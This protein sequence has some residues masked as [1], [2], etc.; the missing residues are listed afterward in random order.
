MT[1]TFTLAIET[2]V[3]DGSLALF[4]NDNLIDGWTGEKNISR[5]DRLLPIISEFLNRNKI[6]KKDLNLIAVSR[7]P[8]NFTGARI[9]LAT[10][11]GLK[12]GLRVRCVGVSL[13]HALAA[14]SSPPP[15]KVITAIL[16][17]K[18]EV[19]R[20]EHAAES[21]TSV[22]TPMPS[23]AVN[24]QATINKTENKTENKAEDATQNKTENKTEVKSFDDFIDEIASVGGETEVIVERRLYEMIGKTLE[25]K[26]AQFGFSLETPL[27]LRNVGDNLSIAV[28]NYAL[29]DNASDN[30]KAIYLGNSNANLKFS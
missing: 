25:L 23:V 16:T 26:T 28:G 30:I 22:K 24:D 3:G 15:I 4:E 20:Q 11:L 6:A 10:A 19:V 2:A 18:N 29:R 27:K 14:L 1:K 17:N 8:G 7:G 5:S 9:G 12:N 21:K 13:M